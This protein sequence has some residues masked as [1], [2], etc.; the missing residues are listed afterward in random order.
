VRVLIAARMRRQFAMRYVAL[1]VIVVSISFARADDEDDDM[2]E[3][4]EYDL[5]KHLGI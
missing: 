1:L 5:H 4:A 3:E 2:P